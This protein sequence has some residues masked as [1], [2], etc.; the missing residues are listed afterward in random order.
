M[1]ELDILAIVNFLISQLFTQAPIFLGL[2][3][4]IGLV[5]QRKKAT[6]VFLGFLKTMLGVIVLNIGT[7]AIWGV[8]TSMAGI[9]SK[10][11]GVAGVFAD[12][13]AAYGTLLMFKVPIDFAYYSS[14]IFAVGFIFMLIIA[15]FTPFKVVYITGHMMLWWTSTV[16]SVINMGMGL[17][18]AP[19][20]VVSSLIC[21]LYWTIPPYILHKYDKEWIPGAAFT[22]GHCQ[23]FGEIGAVWTGKFFSK[24]PKKDSAENIKF[25]GWMKIFSDHTVSMSLATA[26]FML[27]ISAFAGATVVAP[28]T[29][30]MNYLVWAAMQGLTFTAGVMTI[31]LGVRTFLGEITPAFKGIS[32]RLVPGAVPA[33]D[34]PTVFPYGPTAVLVGFLFD[35]SAQ[36]IA[37]LVLIGIR[38]PIILFPGPIPFF[39]D[40]APIGVYGDKA[41]GWKC[42][43]FWG[44]VSGLA[45]VFGGAM[46]YPMTGPLFTERTGILTSNTDQSVFITIIGWIVFLI[47][48]KSLPIWPKL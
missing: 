40:G 9:T 14:M 13:Q 42:A 2:I 25:P 43:A 24:D 30:G 21:A 44:F 22:L 38:Y 37:T 7:G 6:E 3:A 5:L 47:G 23:Y 31:M 8:V 26:A 11:F 46:L 19:L 48:G 35:L 41:G 15:R 32:D 34:C 39:F 20:I 18:G 29:G 45:F 4:L 28:Y 36:I 10:A 1:P 27:G 17:T 12:D 33:L 16:P